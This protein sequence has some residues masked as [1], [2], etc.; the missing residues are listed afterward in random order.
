MT[1]TKKS[2]LETALGYS[3]KNP[4][5]LRTAL[6][7]P[8]SGLPKNNQR[9]E[10]LGDALLQGCISRLLYREKPQW[11]EGPLSK[12][13]GMLVCTESLRAWALDLGLELERGPRSP[14]KASAPGKPLADAMESLLAA[15]FLDAEASGLDAM[16]VVTG[17]LDARFSE[18][19]RSAELGQWEASDAKTTLQERAAAAGLPVPEYVLTQR[20]GPDHEPIFTVKVQVGDKSAEGE[21]QTLKRAQTAAARRLL[22]V[23]GG[24]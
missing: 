1:R 12:L 15:I 7:P 8:S 14:K 3:F 22:V 2:A 9:L 11:Q 17:I 10:F 19:I 23:L 20:S 5:L 4:E 21:G 18:S 6:T 16:A 24:D 13:R